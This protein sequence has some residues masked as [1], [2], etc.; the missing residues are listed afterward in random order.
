MSKVVADNYPRNISQYVPNMEFAADVIDGVHIVTL[1]APE[2]LDADGIWDGVTADA[3]VNTY[4]SADYKNTFDGSSTSVTSTS[5]MID[6]AYGRCLTVVGSAGS[7]H[8]VT[9]IGKDYLGQGMREQ[10]T[11]SGTSIQ[12]GLKAFKFVDKVSVAAGAAGD[13]MDVGWSDVL[14]LPYCAESI[15]GWTEDNV[16]KGVRRDVIDSTYVVVASDASLF[17]SSHAQGFIVG[18]SYV[19][20]IANSSGANANTLEIGGTAVAGLAL[21]ISASDSL[22]DTYSDVAGTDDHGLTGK[23]AL[24]GAIELVSDTGGTNGAGY[25]AIHI[26]ENVRFI[27]ADRT[28]TMTATTGDTR[29]TVLPYTSCDGSVVYE[30]RYA[31]NTTDLHGIEQFNG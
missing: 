3:S 6:A 15:V 25:A 4:T 11:L 28:A 1:G 21:S 23:I 18:M 31:V 12:Y 5:G 26:D 13:T 17:T 30:V 29:G 19:S 24:G 14:G 20:A 9:V 10:F 8:V 16:E 2:A 27:D 7:N 22:G